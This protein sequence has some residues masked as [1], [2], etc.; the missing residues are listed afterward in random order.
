MPREGFLLVEVLA[1]MTISAFLLAALFSVAAMTTRVAGRVDRQSLGIEN[2]SRIMAALTREIERIAPIRWP[3]RGAGFVFS[4]TDTKLVF[5]HE[6][7]VADGGTDIEAVYLE[8]GPTGMARRTGSVSPVAQSFADVATSRAESVFD[9][10]YAIRF[11]YYSQ[12]ADGREAL[13]EAWTDAAQLPVAVRVTLKGRDGRE[14]M[15][16]IRLLVDTEPGCAYPQKAVCRLR[17]GGKDGADP[18]PD[19][20][21][22]IDQAAASKTGEGG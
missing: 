11:A 21:G 15:A 17:P 2:E 19:A 14:A 6:V 20:R 12:L 18:N 7:D 5:A 13:M 8:G 10:R 9:D 16:R 3:G 4:G 1:T 22:R